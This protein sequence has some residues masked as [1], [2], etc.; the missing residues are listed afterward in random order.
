MQYCRNS[1]ATR[2]K[3]AGGTTIDKTSS[4]EPGDPHGDRDG[5]RDDGRIDTQG[6]VRPR[7]AAERLGI[8]L[9]SVYLWIACGRL[10]AVKLSKNGTRV[11]GDSIARAIDSPE[12][13]A[14]RPLGPGADAS[15]EW[16]RFKR[17]AR[18]APYWAFDT[19]ATNA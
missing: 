10:Q 15:M 3:D 6:L 19:L 9:R 2:A 4:R 18:P 16:A 11:L 13:A 17:S 1:C 5:D 7:E 12:Y 8:S 14:R